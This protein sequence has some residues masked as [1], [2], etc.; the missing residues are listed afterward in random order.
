MDGTGR[1]GYFFSQLGDHFQ[2]RNNT[3]EQYRYLRKHKTLSR[4]SDRRKNEVHLIVQHLL[5]VRHVPL[6]VC[7]VAGKPS[8]DVVV[9]S[10]P[11]A[12][13]HAD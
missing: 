2:Q 12:S 3:Y 5:E 10:S 1:S 6:P 13:T 11:G 8:R 9:Y 4:C 7:G